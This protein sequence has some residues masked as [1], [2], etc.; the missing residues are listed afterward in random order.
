VLER[1]GMMGKLRVMRR[2]KVFAIFI[3]VALLAAAVLF[4]GRGASPVPVISISRIEPAGI[5]AD[6]GG[7]WQLVTLSIREQTNQSARPARLFLEGVSEAVEAKVA[8]RWVGV[9]AS[10]W[11]RCELWPGLC[12]ERS[13]AMPPDAVAC[14]LRVR[15]SRAVLTERQCYWLLRRLPAWLPFDPSIR[16]GLRKKTYQP[17][18]NWQKLQVELPFPREVSSAEKGP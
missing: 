12:R 10:L 1:S 9:D 3:G 6:N 5:F 8:D 13:V 18:G 16:D 14:R 7:E 11:N 2:R 17:G 15:Y 4:V